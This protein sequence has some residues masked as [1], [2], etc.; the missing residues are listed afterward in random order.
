MRA[1]SNGA[2]QMCVPTRTTHRMHSSLLYRP[3]RRVH[4]G[5]CRRSVA[6]PERSSGPCLRQAF[7]TAAATCSGA[8]LAAARRRP[9]SPW[10]ENMV[11]EGAFVCCSPKKRPAG[12]QHW[13]G[14]PSRM[15]ARRPSRVLCQP[16]GGRHGRLAAGPTAEQGSKV[17]LAISCW[18]F[19]EGAIGPSRLPLPCSG[20]TPRSPRPNHVPPARAFF[21]LKRLTPPLQF[22]RIRRKSQRRRRRGAT[23]VAAARPA[24]RATAA[25]A[26]ARGRRRRTATRRPIA[27]SPPTTASAR[28]SPAQRTSPSVVNVSFGTAICAPETCQTCALTAA[29][30]P[31]SRSTASPSTRSALTACSTPWMALSL[32]R[33]ASS[34]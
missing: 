23:A 25:A 30:H 26:T 17:R 21:S 6:P 4:G 19:V 32:R 33:A 3:V 31:S 20:L 22:C 7:P 28:P 2:A 29:P 16:S 27:S 10:P 15:P 13:Q 18:I 24:R 11:R 8:S 14:S 1:S 34:L 9:S 5:K 12:R